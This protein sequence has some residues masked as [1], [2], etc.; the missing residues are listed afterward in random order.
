MRCMDHVL[1][2]VYEDDEVLVVNKPAGLTVHGDG[3]TDERTLSDLIIE[4]YPQSKDVGELWVNAEGKTIYRPG[5]VHRLD[6]DTSGVL[7]VAKTKTTF[8]FL[9]RQ[10]QDRNVLKVYRAFVYGNIIEDS[11]VIDK[12]IGR[13]K[14]DFRMWSAQPGARGEKR[15]SIT[16]FSVLRRSAS[17]D[18]CFVEVRPKTGRTHQIRVHFKAIHHPVV[19]D[20]LYA[21][22]KESLL[23]FKRHALHAYSLRMKL[24]GDS[25]E[26]EFVAPLPEDFVA[27]ERSM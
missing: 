14:S 11:G 18:V 24:S 27:A 17:K 9:K 15:E 23:G 13:S 12:P 21:K 7:I 26:R 1:D 25:D 22:G 4:K 8:D 20:A 19:G 5:I 2:I 3:R 10:F 16:E 6:R